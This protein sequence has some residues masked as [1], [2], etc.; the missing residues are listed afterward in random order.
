MPASELPP[1]QLPPGQLE[2]G[3]VPPPTW[4]PPAG[5]P[6]VPNDPINTLDLAFLQGTAGSVMRA[7]IE[8]L[9]ADRKAKVQGVP[10]VAKS[11]V[12]EINAFAACDEQHMPLMAIT[13][14]LLQVEAYI[15]QFQAT[16]EIFGTQ[17]LDGYLQIF[18]A[19]QKPR[20]PI[21][22]PPMG[23]VDPAQNADARKVARQHQLFEEQLAFVLGHELAHHHLGHTGCANG[24]SGERAVNVGDPLR[25]LSRVVPITNHAVE[26]Y[27][28]WAG[29]NNLLDAGKRRQGR[30]WNEE[31]AYLTLKFFAKLEP[32]NLEALVGSILNSHPNPGFRVVGVKQAADRWRATGG[33]GWQPPSLP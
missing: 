7:L 21:V 18:A 9:P 6:P 24:Q 27:A 22:E 23:F 1:G 30:P 13:D 5:S 26:G 20:R 32:L 8:A 29:T 31:G 2:P 28:D 14:G 3:G 25:M 19:Q 11:T 4:L 33:V 10:F 15:A 17:K 12:G 16:D